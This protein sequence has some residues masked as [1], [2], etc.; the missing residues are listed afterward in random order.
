MFSTSVF[1]TVFTPVLVASWLSGEA[2]TDAP[3]RSLALS[4]ARALSLSLVIACTT[5]YTRLPAQ[6]RTLTTLGLVVV[7][8]F[9]TSGGFY[10]SEVAMDG[11][12]LY[13]L[14]ICLTMPLLYSLPTALISAELATNY[15]E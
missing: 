1:S 2:A 14:I 3:A 9:W 11:P 6:A 5:R 10:G 12:P 7:G 4:L 8:F 13:V 15:P